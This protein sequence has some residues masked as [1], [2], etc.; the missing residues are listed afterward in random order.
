[1]KEQ[2]ESFDAL[3]FFGVLRWRR[4]RVPEALAL[5]KAALAAKPDSYGSRT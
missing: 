2:Q 5:Q 1:L 3:Q 4:E